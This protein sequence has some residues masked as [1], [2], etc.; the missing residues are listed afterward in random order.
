MDITNSTGIKRLFKGIAKLKPQKPKY[1]YTWDHAT[2]LKMISTWGENKNLN[3]KKVTM[4]LVTLL[5]L[6]TAQRVQ[7]L[8]KI[9]LDNVKEEDRII[10]IAIPETIKTSG[11]NRQQ[12]LLKLPYFDEKPLL[13]VARTLKDYIEKTKD[14][15]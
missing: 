4:K 6:T 11:V 2:V 7:T 14:L 1:D 15:R 12:P 3:L 10:Q 8:S 13:C 9:K 5:A